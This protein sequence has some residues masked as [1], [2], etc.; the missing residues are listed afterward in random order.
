MAEMKPKAITFTTAVCRSA[1]WL[2]SLK[3]LKQRLLVDDG[4]DHG[5]AKLGLGPDLL[6]EP[7]HLEGD[8]DAE[9]DR[10]ED[11]GQ[12]AD[13]G[14]EPALLEELLQGERPASDQPDRLEGQR[15]HAAGLLQEP[16]DLPVARY[17][18]CHRPVPPRARAVSP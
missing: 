6:Q 2:S 12:G 8:D 7:A 16:V 10:D 13:L 9:W 18:Y 14:Q 5:R 3:P 4:Q 11:D 17:H 15:E 1:S